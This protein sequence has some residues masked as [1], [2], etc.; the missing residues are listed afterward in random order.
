M[1]KTKAFSTIATII[2]SILSLAAAPAASAQSY[3]A[4]PLRGNR[5]KVCDANTAASAQ[6]FAQFIADKTSSKPTTTT[7]PA[8][9]GPIQFHGAYQLPTT[10]ANPG[11]IAVVDA[12]DDPTITADLAVYNKTFGLSVF[13]SCSATVTTSCFLKVN[14]NGSTNSYPQRSSSWALETSLDIETA[15]Q[16]CQNC[17]LI[18]VEANSASYTSLLTAVDRARL[19]GATVISNSYGS[20]EFGTETSYDT[21]FNYPGVTFVFSS[22][23]SGYGA[24]YPAAS[25]LVT[26]AGGTTLGINTNNTWQSETVWTGGGS[27]CSAYEFKPAFQSSNGCQKRTIADLSADADPN[28]GAAV[29]DSYTYGGTKGWFQVGGTSLAAPIIA[30]AYALANNVGVGTYANSV[31]YASF[32]YGTNLRDVSSGQNGAC[33]L[34]YLCQAAAGYDGPSGL[35][36]PLGLGAF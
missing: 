34:A 31:P 30:G 6:C 2:F 24:T 35:G 32:I 29:Y 1:K 8:G 36:T 14:Q 5:R 12:Y 17:K 7:L 10:S 3:S 11:I 15:H 25:P 26:S 9:Y 19:M 4:H 23:D 13:P 27:G 22:G 20:G 16:I 18:L 33:S 21:H 28:T